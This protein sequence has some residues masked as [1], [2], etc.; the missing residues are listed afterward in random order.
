MNTRDKG[1]SVE[2]TLVALLKQIIL[3]KGKRD[4]NIILVY[5]NKRKM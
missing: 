2:E 3:A 4:N 5:L 1:C